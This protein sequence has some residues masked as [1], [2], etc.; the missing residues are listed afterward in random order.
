[1]S[2]TPALLRQLIEAE[3]ELLITEN[4]LIRFDSEAQAACDLILETRRQI[5]TLSTIRDSITRSLRNIEAEIQNAVSAHED[6][7]QRATKLQKVMGAHKEQIV[8]LKAKVSGIQE[9]LK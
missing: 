8:K 7:N 5:N 1:M 2:F 3:R 6:A 4:N 9:Q